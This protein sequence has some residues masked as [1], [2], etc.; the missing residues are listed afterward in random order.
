MKVFL[1][2]SKF[3][4]YGVIAGSGLGLYQYQLTLNNHE[5]KQMMVDN[6][7]MYVKEK[8]DKTDS[9]VVSEENERILRKGALH[10]KNIVIPYFYYIYKDYFILS[11]TNLFCWIDKSEDHLEDVRKF[12]H[13]KLS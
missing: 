1:K 3:F 5:V 2:T 11:L 9:S 7:K 12:I 10:D 6:L 13:K 4:I 8:N